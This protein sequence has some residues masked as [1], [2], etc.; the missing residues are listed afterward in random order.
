MSEVIVEFDFQPVR[1]V[2]ADG[3]CKGRQVPKIVLL[4][5]WK[6]GGRPF[7]F[8]DNLSKK[9]MS[10]GCLTSVRYGVAD[11]LGTSWS[12]SG[13]LTAVPMWPRGHVRGMYLDGFV[14]LVQKK[15]EN[16]KW[17]YF[18]PGLSCSGHDVVEQCKCVGPTSSWLALDRCNTY[19]H[20]TPSIESNTE[21]WTDS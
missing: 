12:S 1:I 21:M 14:Y 16:Q 15:S 4:R 7:F 18:W 8:T 11:G 10:R 5:P 3:R 9:K 6:W 2:A 19:T 13:L 17:N 20:V